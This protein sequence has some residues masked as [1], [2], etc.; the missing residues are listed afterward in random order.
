MIRT[1]EKFNLIGRM[2]VATYGAVCMPFEAN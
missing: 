2:A 1:L